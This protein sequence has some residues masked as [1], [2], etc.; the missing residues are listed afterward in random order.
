MFQGLPEVNH[1]QDGGA[2][3]ETHAHEDRRLAMLVER[4]RLN[5]R[6]PSLLRPLRRSLP[7]TAQ[8]TR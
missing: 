4:P 7:A 5:H 8:A 3:R 6:D 1:R 2:D